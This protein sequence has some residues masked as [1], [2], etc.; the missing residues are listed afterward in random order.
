M[1]RL[2][3]VLFFFASLVHA[4]DRPMIRLMIADAPM[5]V[6]DFASN[7]FMSRYGVYLD[8]STWWKS[9]AEQRYAIANLSVCEVAAR[10]VGVSL[11]DTV[12]LMKEL[13]GSTAW[14][15][16]FEQEALALNHDP[17]GYL[18]K[19]FASSELM[20]SDTK[21]LISE[22]AYFEIK[23]HISDTCASANN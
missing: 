15:R 22:A 8:S 14:L 20:K 12:K 17:D 13:N 7:C 11:L 9:E 21:M 10:T 6:S 18:A 2:G 16:C 19:S 23:R 3:L 4:Q 5:R 1:W